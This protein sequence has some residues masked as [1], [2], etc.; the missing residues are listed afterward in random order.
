MTPAPS[1]SARSG[2]A[3]EVLRKVDGAA[4]AG[5]EALDAHRTQGGDRRRADDSDLDLEGVGAALGLDVTAPVVPAW[6][7]ACA[8]S[9]TWRPPA[10]FWV[11]STRSTAGLQLAS[12]CALPASIPVG[13]QAWHRRG[14]SKERAGPSATSC[15]SWSGQRSTGTSAPIWTGIVTYAVWAALSA[16]SRRVGHL[17][18]HGCGSDVAVGGGQAEVGAR[19]ASDW[20][21]SSGEVDR[22]SGEVS[23]TLPPRGSLT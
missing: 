5:D 1:I 19:P 23:V 13:S 10:P 14:M 11:R 18:H 20:R 21:F 22:V 2:R 16:G 7:P 15:T 4:R 8:L 17:E 6:A 12:Y 9:T 3:V